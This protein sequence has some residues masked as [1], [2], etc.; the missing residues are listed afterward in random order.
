MSRRVMK[1]RV[2]S[3]K[4]E[5]ETARGGNA[6]QLQLIVSLASNGDFDSA[7]AMARA[8]PDRNVASEAWRLLSE[9]KANLQRWDEA[10]FHI[11]IALQHDPNSRR[12][13]FAR[14]LLLEQA[15][16]DDAALVELEALARDARDSPQLL[17]HLAAQLVYAGRVDEAEGA[18]VAALDT[19]PADA[20]LHTQLARLRWQRGAGVAAFRSIERAIVQLPGELHLRLVAADQLRSAG[21]ANA[22]LALLEDGLKLAPDSA[23]FR[24]S[25]GTL[26]EGMDR[27]DEAL[28]HLLEA[29]ALAPQSAAAARNLVPALLRTG[30]LR[31]A[32]AL[33]DELLVR[34]PLDQMLIAQRATALRLLG[35]PE[36]ARLFDYARL[37]KVYSLQPPAP[38]GSLEEFN[39]I[40][41]RELA[42]LHRGTQHPLEQSLRGGSQTERNLPRDNPVF[43]AFFAMLDAPIRE[44]SGEL[45]AGDQTHPVDRR[46]RTGYRIS[47]SWSVQ[48]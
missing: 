45:R 10:I 20:A 31:D 32:L 4:S 35:D 36:Y 27:L 3:E 46:A 48:L 2:M 17:V 9:V 21:E 12:L 37:V 22:A 19:W 44:Y 24:T 41:A 34:F 25:I 26:L 40:F 5:I 47:G 39:A 38:Y 43:A 13:R 28:P 29:R 33:C 18:L 8:L 16:A 15:G 30:A 23:A 42:P 6:E 1:C 7:V 11:E 14:A